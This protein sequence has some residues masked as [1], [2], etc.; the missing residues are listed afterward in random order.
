MLGLPRFVLQPSVLIVLW[1]AINS[2]DPN[3]SERTGTFF[4][5]GSFAYAWILALHCCIFRREVETRKWYVV[6]IVAQVLLSEIGP[7]CDCFH[8]V[9]HAE[10]QM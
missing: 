5:A 1:N 6:S 3:L 9:K 7:C 2:S 4:A 8:N 10:R